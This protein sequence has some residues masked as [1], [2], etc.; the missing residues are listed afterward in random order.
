MSLIA[1]KFYDR[2]LIIPWPVEEVSSLVD[3]SALTNSFKLSASSGDRGLPGEQ[4]IAHKNYNN[5]RLQNL[6][7]KI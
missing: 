1:A 6:N 2:K 4:N 3:L 5:Y 7:N